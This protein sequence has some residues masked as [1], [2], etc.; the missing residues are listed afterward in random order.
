MAPWSTR[1]AL[2]SACFPEADRRHTM[3]ARAHGLDHCSRLERGE[4]CFARPCFLVRVCSA[5]R[6]NRRD[7]PQSLG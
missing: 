2:C 7:E 6:V 5:V 4:N 1:R 3:S